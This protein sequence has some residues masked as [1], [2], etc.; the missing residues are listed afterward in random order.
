MK[1]MLSG[2]LLLALLAACA[3]SQT[4]EYGDWRQQGKARAERGELKWSEYYRGCFSRLAD[5]PNGADG[6]A[7]ELEYYHLM[8]SHALEYEAG[9]LTISQFEEKRRL[10]QIEK[11]RN[12]EAR[13]NALHGEGGGIHLQTTY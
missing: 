9:R 8:I 11:A 12:K 5:L 6:K 4:K 10:A 3:T 13:K 7:A 2:M 1:K